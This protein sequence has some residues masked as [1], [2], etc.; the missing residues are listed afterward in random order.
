[1]AKLTQGTDT[2]RDISSQTRTFRNATEAL[3]FIVDSLAA[4][5]VKERAQCS[6]KS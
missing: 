3:K 2:A 5:V 6:T 1:M 4:D